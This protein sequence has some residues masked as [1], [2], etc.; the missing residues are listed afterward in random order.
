MR[1]WI[2]EVV[3]AAVLS[4]AVAGLVHAI[5][6]RA[7]DTVSPTFVPPRA[8]ASPGCRDAPLRPVVIS[9]VSGHARVCIVDDRLS[10]EV[11]A[12]SLTERHTYSA[13]FSYVDRDRPFGDDAR[14]GAGVESPAGL[15]GRFD[16][17]V[18]DAPEASF[19]TQIQGLR[20]AARSE[21]TVRLYARPPVAMDDPAARTYQLLLPQPSERDAGAIAT[22]AVGSAGSLVA[23][24]TFDF[25][26]ESPP[27]APPLLR[28]GEGPTS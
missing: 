27:S 19:S 24:A 15:A 1:R 26:A 13:W 6:A 4:L 3:V 8:L 2:G 25:E 7:T 17:T 10:V 28:T 23:V 12:G 9:G 5:G 20:P 14:P 22:V 18:A 21:I 16:G 11:V